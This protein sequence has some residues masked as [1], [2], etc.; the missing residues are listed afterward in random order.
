[1]EPKQ[2]AKWNPSNVL[3]NADTGSERHVGL[4]NR[5]QHPEWTPIATV[6]PDFQSVSECSNDMLGDMLDDML[7]DVL[8][9]MP[10][11]PH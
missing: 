8:G 7:S 3:L 2:C 1:V 11:P 4:L 6:Q 10:T 9:D 5:L